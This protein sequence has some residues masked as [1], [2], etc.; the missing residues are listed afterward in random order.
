MFNVFNVNRIRFVIF[1]IFSLIF[2]FCM[3]LMH[4]FFNCFCFF[5][6]S[7]LELC[8]C[9][10]FCQNCE[11]LF[12][13]FT[14][15]T[16]QIFFFVFNGDHLNNNYYLFFFLLINLLKLLF[17]VSFVVVTDVAVVVALQHVVGV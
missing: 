7:Y 16:F 17:K 5:F 14:T 6:V 13:S 1:W 11:Y 12:N 4:S 15:N 8:I 3:H 10:I 2:L 9:A